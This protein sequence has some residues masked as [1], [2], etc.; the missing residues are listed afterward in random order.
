MAYHI[1]KD[2]VITVYAADGSQVVVKTDHAAYGEVKKLLIKK[3]PME[4]VFEAINKSVESKLMKVIEENKSENLKGYT[5]SADG[6]TILLN[7]SPVHNSLTARALELKRQGFPL[8]PFLKFLENLAQN[9]SA[10][11][12][13]ELYDF[14]DRKALPL[15][16]DGHFL[17][18][19]SIR[20]D[21]RDVYSGTFDNSVGSVVEIARNQV[22]DDRDHECSFGLHVGGSDYVR[23]YGGSNKRI[24]VVKVNPRDCVSVPKDHNAGKLR[25]CRYEVLSE[26]ADQSSF[27]LESAAYTSDGED[28]DLHMEYEDNDD[29][30]NE[31]WE[32]SEVVDA[33]YQLPKYLLEKIWDKVQNPDC[34]IDWDHDSEDTIVSML[35]WDVYDLQEK[36]PELFDE[37]VM[38]YL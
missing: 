6:S 27:E 21:W 37:I 17:A 31:K 25:V 10:R 7:G 13:Q 5:L 11:A 3:A 34:E 23:W 20:T 18:Y 2:N 26:V 36:D 14:L 16:E 15:T 38:L 32:R 22:D 19:K 29:F 4:Q 9:P 24:V 8:D 28:W 35:S 30:V 12:V 1:S 33:L